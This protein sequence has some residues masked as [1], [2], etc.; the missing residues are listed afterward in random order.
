ME[1]RC[2]RQKW[3]VGARAASVNGVYRIQVTIK[4]ESNTNDYID[5][6][7]IGVLDPKPNE[8]GEKILACPNC[9]CGG[10]GPRLSPPSRRLVKAF[11]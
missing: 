5:L 11:R 9:G 6:S 1:G 3:D 2:S 8:L 10:V 7:S 4:V